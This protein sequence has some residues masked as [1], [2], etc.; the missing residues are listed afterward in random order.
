MF[1]L[2]VNIGFLS[3]LY[4]AEDEQGEWH[5]VLNKDKYQTIKQELLYESLCEWYV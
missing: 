4:T 1:F 3:R 2:L 5:L